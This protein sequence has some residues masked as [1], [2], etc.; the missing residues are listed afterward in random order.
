MT[1]ARPAFELESYVDTSLPSGIMLASESDLKGHTVLALITD[2]A[3]K[4]CGSGDVVIVTETLCW[5]VIRAEAEYDDELSIGILNSYR[6]GANKTER[7]TDYLSAGDMYSADLINKPEFDILVAKEDEG[8]KIANKARADRMR[9]Q[10]EE[11]EKG[12]R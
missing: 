11:I 6:R 9:A 4:E 12:L 1:T 10:A 5:L 2:P 7:L 8:K 3:G